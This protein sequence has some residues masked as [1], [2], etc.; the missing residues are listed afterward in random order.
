MPLNNSE[1]YN[2]YFVLLCR[3]LT[4]SQLDPY[5]LR[6]REIYHLNH[7][8]IYIT[9]YLSVVYVLSARSI[10]HGPTVLSMT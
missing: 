4:L 7:P 10:Q 6:L 3:L 8:L 2:V 1:I 9:S 5:I